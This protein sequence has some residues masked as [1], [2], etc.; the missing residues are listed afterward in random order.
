MS[1]A[2]FNKFN[3]TV[4]DWLNGAVDYGSDPFKVFLTNT[5]PLA[6]N[7]FYSDIPD[8]ATG[9]GYIHGGSLVTMALSNSFGVETVTVTLSSPTWSGV[10]PGFGPFRYAVFYDLNGIQSLQAWFDLGSEI[11]IGNGGFLTLTPASNFFTLS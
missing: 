4:Q 1:T 9:G 10:G 3:L 2:T 5:A 6:T 7:H 8:L 11:S